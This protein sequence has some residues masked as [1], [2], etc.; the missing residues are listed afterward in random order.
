MSIMPTYDE[1]LAIADTIVGA[2]DGDPRRVSGAVRTF[3]LIGRLYFEVT[4]GGVPRWLTNRSGRYTTETVKALEEIGASECAAVVREILGL[5]GTG[6]PE[7]EVQRSAEV[8]KRYPA[9]WP[10]WRELGDCL[11][12][13]P[14]DVDALLR[15]HFASHTAE[16]SV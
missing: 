11:L 4:A 14:D 12:D 13:W 3:H 1:A 16:F 6:L 2:H 15:A 9:A 10:R 8:E 7:D 5:F